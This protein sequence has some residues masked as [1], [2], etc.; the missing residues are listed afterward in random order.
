LVTGY[1]SLLRDSDLSVNIILCVTLCKDIVIMVMNLLVSLFFLIMF[2]VSLG[3]ALLAFPLA[4]ACQLAVMV[5][6]VVV[7]AVIGTFVKDL[8]AF[9][10]QA[11]PLMWY[12]SPAMY[13]LS[14]ASK[15]I[16]AFV[17]FLKLNPL[18]W[19]LPPYEQ[20]FIHNE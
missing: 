4:L 9:A 5:P 1:A 3:K 18:Y 16:P 19:I 8:G 12:L 6:M 13:P 2:R 20:I 7:F 17:P 14:V 11:L 15:R 10:G